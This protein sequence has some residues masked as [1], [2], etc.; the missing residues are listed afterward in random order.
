MS[1]PLLLG[2]DEGTTAVKAALFDL[3]LRE[4]ARAR[5][6]VPVRHPG[7][8]LVEQDP[9]AI[10]EA[11]LDAVAEV[12]GA[13][14]GR[15]VI[16]AGL[17]HQGESVLA[18][19]AG[20]GRPLTP[21]IV[22]QDKRSE[23]LLASI[24]ERASERSGLPLDPYFSA[25]KL[26]WMLAHEQRVEAARAAGS[27]RM[28]TLDAFI[29]ERLG[30]GFETDLS[31]ASRMQLL[32]VGG[33]DWDAELLELFGLRR[34]WLARIAPTVG[35]L[36]ELSSVRWP[37][38]L[39]LAARLVDQQAALA[40]SGAV[41]AGELKATYGTGV[42]VLGRTAAPVRAQ[43]L[44]PTVAWA[45]SSAASGDDSGSEPARLEVAHALDGG[46][47]AAG[48]LLDWLAQGLGLAPD[49]PALAA[50]AAEVPDSSGV[51]V[52]P[53]IS[54]LG[55]PWWE[56]RARG[57]LAGLHPGVRPPHIARAALEAIAWRVADV[58]EAIARE[59]PVIS[60][61]VDGGL[62]N[63]PTLVQLQADALEVPVEVGRPDTTVLGA[64]MLAGVGAGV[65]ADVEDAAQRLAPG[66]A[67]A[68]RTDPRERAGA[69]E[70]WRAFVRSSYSIVT[71]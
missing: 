65:F 67:V 64:A 44:L 13:A 70:R 56:P 31:T 16:A 34:D 42:F 14:E 45:R 18:W 25:G 5:R 57:V 52:L 60:L 55:A 40:G 9:E 15:E 10:L 62:T 8:G 38:P 47:F 48:A 39:R 32:A 36:G 43:G 59:A 30:A 69:R 11:V 58:V 61:R 23:E 66:R 24:D 29:S 68:A 37:A 51:M 28:G 50:R 49:A 4:L 17:D 21:V 46:V 35:E 26:A 41:R 22:W 19:E 53:A 63:D 71:S 1:S 12:L 54:G 3:D 2:I 27:L 33:Q 6:A 20:S 7:S